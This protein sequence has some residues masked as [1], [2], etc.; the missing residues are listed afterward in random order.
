MAIL[1]NPRKGLYTHALR[2]KIGYW[3]R[4]NIKIIKEKNLICFYSDNQEMLENEDDIKTT[5]LGQN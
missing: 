2:V 5:E 1:K 3:G 4:N